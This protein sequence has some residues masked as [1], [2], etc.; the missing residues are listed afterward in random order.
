[1]MFALALIRYYPLFGSET[2]MINGFICRRLKEFLNWSPNGHA[3]AK[4]RKVP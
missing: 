2:C 4:E 3:R 1:M